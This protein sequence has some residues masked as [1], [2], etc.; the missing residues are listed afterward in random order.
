VKLTTLFFAILTAAT[1]QAQLI[2][3]GVKGG[4]HTL[5]STTTID[6]SKR[7]LV[8]PSVEVR[9]PG[10]FA[11]EADAL[12]QRLGSSTRLFPFFSTGTPAPGE[13]PTASIPLTQRQ[14]GNSW[15]FPVLAKY[16]TRSFGP[17]HPFVSG[18]AAF[19][20]IGVDRKGT[21][22]L[23]YTNNVTQTVPFQ[24]SFR[25]NLAVGAVAAV[26]L[27]YKV[28]RFSILPEFRYTRY[29]SDDRFASK[30]SA[31]FLLGISF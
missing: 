17:L 28:G 29:G 16:Y 1:S 22:I 8:G 7:Y 9:L 30:N 6:E 20:T 25:T 12:Y 4:I 11:I 10:N 5:D 14:R 13:S 19:R 18:G 31:N 15:E 27:R 23:I 24:Q 21:N 2:S 26:G 3:I